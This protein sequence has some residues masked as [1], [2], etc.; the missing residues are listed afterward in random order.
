[1]GVESN[2]EWG[3][4]ELQSHGGRKTEHGGRRSEVG[5]QSPRT[6][7]LQMTED[8]TSEPQR[9]EVVITTFDTDDTDF[10]D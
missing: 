9:S 10:T 6:S 4:S 7:E 2:S 1:M 3:T 5:G 8:R